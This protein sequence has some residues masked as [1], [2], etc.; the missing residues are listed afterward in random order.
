MAKF[1]EVIEF[2]ETDFQRSDGSSVSVRLGEEIDWVDPNQ[3]SLKHA[4][5]TRIMIREYGEGPV[6]LKKIQRVPFLTNLLLT[7]VG[8]NERG[9]ILTKPYFR[10]CE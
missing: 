9:F 3:E 4:V 5:A 6:I 8:Q 1:N 7:V 10:V 2:Q